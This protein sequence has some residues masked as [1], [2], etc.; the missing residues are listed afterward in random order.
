MNRGDVVVLDEWVF[1][2][3]ILDDF[4][5][6]FECVDN[7]GF[8]FVEIGDVLE[9]AIEMDFVVE[10]IVPYTFIRFIGFVHMEMEIW[11]NLV[12]DGFE[13]RIFF[14]DFLVVEI[15]S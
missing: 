12:F 5:G 2:E 3:E 14:G 11:G 4:L 1:F 9:I 6:W 10:W 8:I 13:W 15:G 7:V